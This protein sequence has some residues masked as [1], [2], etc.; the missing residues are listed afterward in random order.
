MHFV[1]IAVK[2]YY[3]MNLQGDGSAGKSSST[4]ILPLVEK[5]DSLSIKGKGIKI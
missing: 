5:E 1:F 4:S 2:M 3:I